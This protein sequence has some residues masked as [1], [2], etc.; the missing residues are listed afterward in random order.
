M[1]P[2]I[3]K[4]IH[5]GNV[6]E[7]NL[8]KTIDGPGMNSS[9]SLDGTSNQV[10]EE[11]RVHELRHLAIILHENHCKEEEECDWKDEEWVNLEINHHKAEF[12]D[13]AEKVYNY[14]GFD[15]KAA[16][17]FIEFLDTCPQASRIFFNSLI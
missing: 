6:E 17:T 5:F 13:K 1:E 16:K 14:F 2:C 10:R 12:Y 11:R 3:P 9:L 7:L 8:P 15:F 4:M